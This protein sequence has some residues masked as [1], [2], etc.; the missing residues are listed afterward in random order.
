ME[1][2][3]VLIRCEHCGGTMTVDDNNSSVLMCP[4]CGSK[5]LMRESDSVKIEKIKNETQKEIELKKLEFEERE[6]KRKI[7]T[8]IVLTTLSILFGAPVLLFIVFM[9]VGAIV[10]M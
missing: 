2:T 5:E 3:T 4:Y 9:I 1:N 7:I 10:T 8:K 6:R